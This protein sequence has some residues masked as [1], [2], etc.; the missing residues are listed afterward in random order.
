MA[1]QVKV[2]SIDALESFRASLIVFL[3]TAHRSVDEVIDGVRRTRGWLQ[4][5][6]RL[7]WEGQL[8]RRAKILT[9]AKQELL[10]ARMSG[11]HHTMAT[12]EAAVLKAKHALAEAET[13]LRAVKHWNRDYDTSAEPLTKKMQSLRHFLD[14]DMP[15]AIA[16]LVQAQRTLEAYTQIPAPN[17]AVAPAPE[18]NDRQ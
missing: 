5:D 16:Y 3:G 4:N 18:E 15:K 17:T 2:T 9:E 13:K 6:Q 10:S 11:L 12:R 14:Q 7:H 1:S 8:R